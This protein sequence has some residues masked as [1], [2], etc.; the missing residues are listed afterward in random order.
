[1]F[2]TALRRPCDLL[3]RSIGPRVLAR[4]ALGM[5]VAAGALA[6]CSPAY[7]WR[8]VTNSASG[9]SVDLPAKPGADQRDVEVDG[10]PMHMSMQT[11]EVDHVLFVVGTLALPD[12]E[13][14][15]QQRALSA[16]RRSS[17]PRWSLPT[18]DS[19]RWCSTRRI[20]CAPM[21]S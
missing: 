6:A 21:S 14:A 7:D 5:I 1:M 11:A 13:P 20:F 4:L 18:R 2:P 9:Y 19:A 16:G 3:F 10:T 15:T 8:T 17:P 12:A